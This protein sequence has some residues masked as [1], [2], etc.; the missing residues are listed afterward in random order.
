MNFSASE[1]LESLSF[2]NKLVVSWKPK[3]LFL[4]ITYIK[5]LSTSLKSTSWIFSG[6]K[7]TVAPS[8]FPRVTLR[9]RDHTFC[10]FFPVSRRFAINLFSI[11]VDDQQKV[12]LTFAFNGVFLRI[13]R[14][15][16]VQHPCSIH[17]LFL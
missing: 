8:T 12:A 9:L 5:M 15:L 10:Y 2:Y 7:V 13:F 17:F 11:G 14:Q 16:Q 3:P 1:A 4:S 6:G